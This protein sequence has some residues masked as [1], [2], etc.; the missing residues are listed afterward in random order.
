MSRLLLVTLTLLVGCDF[1]ATG[2]SGLPKEEPKASKGREAPPAQEPARSLSPSE[3]QQRL[4]ERDRYA[5]EAAKLAEEGKLA[6]AVTAAEKALALE[7]QLFGDVHEEVVG[8]LQWIARLQE[9]REDFAAARR[10]C[11][12]VLTIRRKLDGPGHWRV[13]DARR[14]LED[15]E[16]RSGLSPAQRQRLGE[17]SRLN[18]EARA[19]YGRGKSREAIRAAQQALAISKE[20]LGE[21]HPDYANSLNN[22]AELYEAMG[23]Y[24]KA[25]PLCRQALAINK[26]ALGDKHPNYATSL[27]NLAELYHAMG[28]YAKAEPLHRQALATRKEA[29]GERHP[30]YAASLNNLAELYRAMGD[31]AQAEPLLRQASVIWKEALGDRHPDYAASLGNLAGL[32]E[33]MGDYGKAEPLYRQAQAITKEALGDKHPDYARILNNLAALYHAMGDY[34][35][36][37]PLYRQAL[38]TTKEALGERHP[39]YATALNNLAELYREM[40]DYGKAEPLLRQALATTKEGLGDKHPSYATSLNNLALLYREMGDYG[41]AE[42]LY[43][44]A[45]V[46]RKQALGDKHSDYAASLDNLAALYRAMGDYGKAEPL[47]RQAL[48]IKKEALGDKHPSYANTLIS[49]AAL[50]REKGDYA[51]AEP[52][53]R[54]ALAIN[55]QARGDKHPDYAKSLHN[56]A[57]LYQEMDTYAKAE[58]LYRQ[59]LDITKQV[60]GDKHPR[61]ATSLDNLAALYHSMGNYAK[62]E[63]LH[64]QALDITKQVLGDKHPRYAV[65]LSNL[66]ALYHSMGDYAKAEP[67]SRQGLQICRDNLDLAAAAQSE[68]Q[69]LAMTAQLRYILDAYLTLA[70]LA[71]RAGEAAYAPVLAWKGAVFMQQHRQRLARSHPEL[72]ALFDKLQDVSRRLATRALAVPTPAQHEAWHRNLVQLTEEKENLEAELARRNVAFRRQQQ[73]QKRTPADVQQAL[74]ADVALLDFLEYGHFEP[75]AKKKGKSIVE[76]RL[77]AFVI[78]PGRKV[79]TVELGAVKPLAEAIDQWRESFGNY[80]LRPNVA[81]AQVL[82]DKLWLPLERHVKGVKTVLV[83]PDGVLAKL[84]LAALPGDKPGSYLIETWNFATVAVPQLLPSLLAPPDKAEAAPPSLLLVGDVDYGATP[85][86]ADL[87]ASRS[88]PGGSRGWDRNNW[89]RLPATRDEIQGIEASFRGTFRGAK[90]LTLP[91]DQATENAIRTAAPNY[92]YL[93]L[94]T[95]GYFAPKELRSALSPARKGNDPLALGRDLLG[96]GG[97]VGYHPGLLSGVVLAGANRAAKEGEDDGVLTATEVAALDLSRVET[98]VLSACETGLGE[99]AGGEGLLGLQRAFQESGAH[100]VVAGLWQ[101]EDECTRR[102]M[103]RFYANLWHKQMGKLAAL[104]EAQLWMLREGAKQ[105]DVLRGLQRLPKE[106]RERTDGK[107]PPYYWAAFVLSGDW[108]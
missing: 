75:D 58:P 2:K 31:Y 76:G 52:L 45:L 44:Q 53:L 91:Q 26:E 27:N 42:P 50:Y 22:L 78:R 77:I 60:L 54:Q 3:R 37:V 7:R 11:R 56:L 102:L 12:E 40:G 64:R 39:N 94:A 20:V 93:H 51:K 84:P 5:Q 25:E 35:K 73:E 98:V 57:D 89:R 79:E 83:S 97:V 108:R 47:H 69:Q 34:A 16:R 48:A 92:R 81:A 95:H 29:L 24:G 71:Q 103:E 6:E 96:R 55:K 8:S 82:R 63:P 61:Y 46:I 74:P 49:L 19:L 104:R 85:G 33:S 67:F 101:V 1:T 17:A 72:T 86:L 100:T 28:D 15:L 62:A 32:Y 106:G 70:P 68:R 65:G 105:P 38:A 30:H 36:A 10:A 41:K 18:E 88:A 90:Y 80:G 59:A 14:A 87:V 21:R 13:A 9:Q 99:V 43:R 107:L 66:A 4:R 23:D